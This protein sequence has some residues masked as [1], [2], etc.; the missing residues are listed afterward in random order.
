MATVT[1]TRAEITLARSRACPS[2]MLRVPVLPGYAGV[3]VGF[4]FA[5]GSVTVEGSRHNADELDLVIEACLRAG[6]LPDDHLE[7]Y[8]QFV[9][10]R[11]I[12]A[13]DRLSG[14]AITTYLRELVR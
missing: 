1:P 4:V 10:A 8:V 7:P 12:A 13:P 2:G 14:A 9:I 3:P 5:V 11:R 6:R